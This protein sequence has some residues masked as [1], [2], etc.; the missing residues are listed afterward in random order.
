MIKRHV[1]YYLGAFFINLVIISIIF[2]YA[3]LV[4]FGSNNFLSSDLGTQYRAFLTELRRQ[5]VSGNVHLYLFSQSL[6][7]NFFPVMSYYLLSPFNLILVLFSPMGIPA[8]ANIIIMLKISVMGVTM[9]YFL[10]SY[11][12]EIKYSNY[13]FTLAYSFCGFVASY[14]YDLMWLDALIM[15]PLVAVGV[16]HVLRKQ[17]YVLHFFSILLSI[18][19]NY[20]L[21]YMLCIFSLCFFI[22][23]WLWKK[24][25]CSHKINGRSFAII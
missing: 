14:F 11:S 23:I 13:L 22:Y 16:M 3:G 6:G 8:A 20:Y 25:S 4:P 15:L 7:D 9:A 10:K 18:I 19:F 1:P 24:T 12:Q 2:A 5:L 17:K 21:G